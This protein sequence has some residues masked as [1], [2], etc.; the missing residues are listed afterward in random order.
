MNDVEFSK[1]LP[2]DREVSIETFAYKLFKVRYAYARASETQKYGDK[3]QDFL[4]FETSGNGFVFALCD[5][6]SQSFYGELAASFLGIS[7]RQWLLKQLPITMNVGIISNLLDEHLVAITEEASRQVKK[8]PV[9][10]DALPLLQSVLEEKR[11]KGSETTFICGRIDLPGKEFPE[12]RAV[13]SW[14]GDSRLRLWSAEEEITDILGG[15]FETR[16][17]W[18][19]KRGPV[20]KKPNV[21]VGVLQGEKQLSRIAAYSDGISVYDDYANVLM[22]HE[23]QN[24]INHAGER[25]DSDDI[26][27]LEIILD[28]DQ[29]YEDASWGSVSKDLFIKEGIPEN[30]VMGKTE[31]TH[32]I[33]DNDKKEDLNIKEDIK[34]NQQMPAPEAIIPE[35]AMDNIKIER[36]AGKEQQE[37]LVLINT[38]KNSFKLHRIFK[39]RKRLCFILVLLITGVLIAIFIKEANMIKY[40]KDMPNILSKLIS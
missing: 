17:R 22:H 37:N 33:N 18:S 2:Q 40:F 23:I 11:E 9:P 3:G 29:T 8:H 16:E 20:G 25:A 13:F 32:K 28:Y 12:G 15:S 1:E 39:N 26:S 21:F 35:Q 27:F 24:L 6:V 10:E 38:P 19:S 5:G 4:T 7:L 31:K 14:L 30:E 36:Q 34:I